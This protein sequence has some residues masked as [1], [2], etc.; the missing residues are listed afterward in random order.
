MEMQNVV[1]HGFN[2]FIYKVHFN[3]EIPNKS[4][5]V[6]LKAIAKCME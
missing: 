2:H 1:N 4:Q 5:L 3:L 6:E